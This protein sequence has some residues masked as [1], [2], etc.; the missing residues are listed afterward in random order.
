[1][2]KRCDPCS[3]ALDAGQA[4]LLKIVQSETVHADESGL[5]V[6]GKL[7]WLHAAVTQECTWYGVHAHRAKQ[8]SNYNLLRCLEKHEQEVLRFMRDSSV[9]FTN[10]LAKQAMRMPKVKQRISGSYRVA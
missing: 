9:P 2:P 3:A 5:R 7:Y 8:S 4:Q 6:E 1:V 10:N